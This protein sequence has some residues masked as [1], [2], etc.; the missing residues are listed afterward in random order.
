MERAV[1]L[2]QE[3]LDMR[4]QIRLSQNQIDQIHA[5]INAVGAHYYDANF[6]S[7]DLAGALGISRRQLYRFLNRSFGCTPATFIREFRLKKAYQVIVSGKENR[8]K[9]VA[10]QTGHVKVAHFSKNFHAYHGI[11]P[12]EL[13]KLSRRV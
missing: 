2:T 6:K 4:D 13:I 12:S 11:L 7:G 5:L 3:L 8:V 1:F 9:E 10:A